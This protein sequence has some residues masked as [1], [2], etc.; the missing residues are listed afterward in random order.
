MD[1]FLLQATI[2]LLTAVVVLPLFARFGLSSIVGYLVVGILIGPAFGLVGSEVEI[3]QHFAEIGIVI[4]LFLIGLELEP[5]AL[6]DM[7]KNVLGLGILQIVLTTLLITAFALAFG[8][9]WQFS[10]VIGLIF[11]L[12]STAIVLQMLNEKG[13][14]HTSGGHNALSTL[15]TQDLAIIPILA[16][17]PLLVMTAAP[18]DTTMLDASYNGGSSIPIAQELLALSGWGKTALMI[19]SVAAIAFGGHFLIQVM[20]RFVHQTKLREMYIATSLLF[21]FAVSSLMIQ[22]GLSPAM[23][24]FLGGIVLANSTYRHELKSNLDPFKGL[25]L[26][27]FFITVGAQIDFTIFMDYLFVI[28]G[29]T[30]CIIAIKSMVLFCLGYVFRVRGKNLGLFVLSL[31]GASEFAFILINFS[32]QQGLFD[33]TDKH[34]LLVIVAFSMFLTPLLFAGY[35][36]ALAMISKTKTV[37]TVQDEQG[38]LEQQKVI[39]AGS[40]RF[41]QVINRVLTAAGVKTIVLDNDLQTINL[42]RRFGFK[43]FF[44]DPTR[45]DLLHAAGLADAQV[46]VIAVDDKE[47]AIKLTRYVRSVNA[48]VHIVARAYDRVHTYELYSAGANQI[49]REVFDSAL[50]AGRYVLENTGFSEF[51]AQEL[52]RNFSVLDRKIVRELADLWIPGMPVR[53][54]HDYIKRSKELNNTLETALVN[55][56]NEQKN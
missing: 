29:L 44:G 12:S 32:N 1:I 33:Q 11:S 53:K 45:P 10:L 38:I 28:V 48:N 43:G 34:I 23:G 41:G 25:L 4:M 30:L 27:L 7:R 16:F 21:V 19:A 50:R 46:M 18:A 49:V 24:S 3:L 6:W 5:K 20:F 54:N 47:A 36:Q 56:M 51:E 42:M 22:V 52:T 17:I 15:L 13:L 14:T 35:E 40:G 39:I 26:G 37:K 8:Q 31:S 2:Y 55:A 9:N